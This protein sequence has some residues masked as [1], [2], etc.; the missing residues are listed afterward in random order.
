[1]RNLLAA[2]FFR[3][4]KDILLKVAIILIAVF[5][6]I[7][8]GLYYVVSLMLDETELA[9]EPFLNARYLYGSAFGISSDVGMIIPIFTGAIICKDFSMG[10]VRNKIIRGYARDSIFFS[11]LF[12]GMVFGCILFALYAAALLGLG[13][14]VLGYGAEIDSEEIKFLV[15][16]FLAGML[17]FAAMCAFE[18]MIAVST[19]SLG[20]T[21]VFYIALAI[22]LQMIQGIV[23]M[24]TWLPEIVYEI[25]NYLPGNLMY[26]VMEGSKEWDVYAKSML[27]SAVL[28]VAF[29]LIGRVVFRK[30]DLK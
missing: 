29:A 20:L 30:K 18:S 13:T 21:I 8:C 17:S 19:G 1:M 12:S 6:C 15:I 11:H 9:A 3:Q 22:G 24:I 7:G 16:S 10:T 23:S 28:L 5:A 4:R 2:D 14:L 27:V 26:S 25:M